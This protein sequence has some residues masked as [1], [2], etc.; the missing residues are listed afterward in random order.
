MFPTSLRRE[1]RR[2]ER[3]GEGEGGDFP[4]EVCLQRRRVASWGGVI[5]R[6]VRLSSDDRQMIVVSRIGYASSCSWAK[7]DPRFVRW[8]W[9]LTW[10]NVTYLVSSN[11]RGATAGFLEISHVERRKRLRRLP[12]E[13]GKWSDRDDSN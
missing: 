5:A 12:E 8:R 1:E 3:A 7:A 6:D 4:P 13:E 10:R 11:L 2:R 9:L